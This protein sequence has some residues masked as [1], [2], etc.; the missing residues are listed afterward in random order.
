[1]QIGISFPGKDKGRILNI[2]YLAENNKRKEKGK[3]VK[4][5][6]MEA[7]KVGGCEVEM[8]RYRCGSLLS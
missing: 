2:K 6:R 7:A 1:M 8:Q 5:E 4:D 3:R